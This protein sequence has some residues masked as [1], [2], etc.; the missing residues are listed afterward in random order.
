[1]RHFSSSSG[2][3]DMD[4]SFRSD[5][6]CSFHCRAVDQGGGGLPMRRAPWLRGLLSSY[7]MGGALS[8]R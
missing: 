6:W 3:D 5:L 4:D 8:C 2:R 1:M 7:G